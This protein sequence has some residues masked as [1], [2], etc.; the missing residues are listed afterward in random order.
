MRTKWILQYSLMYHVLFPRDSHHHS[1]ASLWHEWCT[2]SCTSG[3]HPIAPPG[4]FI[5]ETT[6]RFIFLNIDL[7]FRSICN[8]SQPY[9]DCE[10]SNEFKRRFARFCASISAEART[11]AS[12]RFISACDLVMNK[13][14]KDSSLAPSYGSV[15]REIW[16]GT[17]YGG[18]HNADHS[19]CHKTSL[20][21]CRPVGSRDY[22][23][24]Y[25]MDDLV[26]LL[27]VRVQLFLSFACKPQMTRDPTVE[28][29]WNH[30]NMTPGQFGE[31]DVFRPSRNG[32]HR[33]RMI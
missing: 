26:I 4:R 17:I 27:G 30:P 15:S 25:S 10:S 9:R 21:E 19:I 5:S 28:K 20:P 3:F 7:I 16:N 11:H 13:I 14:R 2:C 31:A 1:W 6:Q 33:L 12:W 32:I 8:Q 24:F 29:D 23:Q 18:S 22:C